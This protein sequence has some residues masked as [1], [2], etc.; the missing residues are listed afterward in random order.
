MVVETGVFDQGI[1]KK[2]KGRK[3]GHKKESKRAVNNPI[4]INQRSIS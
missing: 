4:L 1:H 2:K 3:K